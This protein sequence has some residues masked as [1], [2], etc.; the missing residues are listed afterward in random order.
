MADYEFL[1]RDA[2]VLARLDD[3]T[4][5]KVEHVLTSWAIEGFEPERFQTEAVVDLYAGEID[6]AQFEARMGINAPVAG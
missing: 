3:S 4:R 2:D 6:N 5:A 1:A